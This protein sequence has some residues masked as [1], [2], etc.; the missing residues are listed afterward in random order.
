MS[1]A[2]QSSRA[3]DETDARGVSTTR[4]SVLATGA[5]LGAGLAA[6]CVSTGSAGTDGDGASLTVGYQP[7]YTES[8]SALVI[9]HA[10]LA[11][12]YLPDGY[13]V[14]NWQVALQGAV[15]GNRMI[16]GKAQVGYTG[17]MPTITAIANDETDISCTG[18]AGYSQGQQCNLGIVPNA[19]GVEGVS[20]LAGATLGLTTGACTHRFVLRLAEKEG[21]DIQIKDQGINTIQTGIRG[22]GLTAGFG[23]EPVM[24]KTVKQIDAGRYLVTGASYDTYDAAGIIMPDSLIENHPDAARQ[25]MKAELEAKKIMAEE[26]E[27]TLDLVSQE[28]ELEGYD[29]S[30][31]RGVLYENIAARDVERLLFATDYTSA[32][33][34]K[35]LMKQR[36]PSFLKQQ[37]IIESIPGDDRFK[38][39][40]MQS[41]IE[42]LRGE[43]DWEVH[44][45]AN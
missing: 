25:W 7:Y 12:K 30:V 39:E 10:G 31:L 38:P 8:W 16:A 40:P 2:H 3:E 5:T 22:G 18:I 41:A 43:V 42:E 20:D 23:W 28:S 13:S 6:G 17:D 14:G 45:A 1:T 32:K 34:A 4:R 37:G 27:R 35:R 29:R 36:A 11:E 24:Y 15:V 33:P 9:K 26:P 21:I 19:S 44:R